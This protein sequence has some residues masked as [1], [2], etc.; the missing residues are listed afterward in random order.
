MSYMYVFEKVDVLRVVLY[1]SAVNK[2]YC[3]TSPYIKSHLM[4]HA[5]SQIE[6]NDSTSR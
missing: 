1:K 2:T 5:I 4:I 6:C 3:Y